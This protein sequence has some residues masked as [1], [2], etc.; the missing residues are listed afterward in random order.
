MVLRKAP[1]GEYLDRSQAPYSP[2]P[3]DVI[4]ALTF[5]FSSRTVIWMIHVKYARASSVGAAGAEILGV[6]WTDAESL[7]NRGVRFCAT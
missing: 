6:K 1:S 3:L 5:A 4:A 2:I 7:C